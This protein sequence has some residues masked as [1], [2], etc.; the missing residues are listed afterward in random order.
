MTV[1]PEVRKM[2]RVAFMFPGQGSFE[3]GMGRD[4]AE[5][6]PEAMAVYDEGS[7]ASGVDLKHLCFDAPVAELVE[8]EVQQPALVSTSLARPSRVH[9]SITFRIRKRRPLASASC[10]KSIAQHSFSRVGV[11][12]GWRATAT[13]LRL[14]RRTV[15]PS[16]R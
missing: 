3:T 10:M 14:R 7:A 2:G 13:R 8:T 4:I 6:V 16:S 9:T 12:S 11:G 1:E 15:R 5:A